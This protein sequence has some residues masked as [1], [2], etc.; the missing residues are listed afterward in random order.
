M[1]A[2]STD[3]PGV[4][5]GAETDWTVVGIIFIIDDIIV[6]GISVRLRSCGRHGGCG[7]QL[8]S[9]GQ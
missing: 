4:G 3:P 6:I 9:T 8:V 2:G 5:E 7:P 1:A